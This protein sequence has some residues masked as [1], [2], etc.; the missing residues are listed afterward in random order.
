MCWTDEGQPR[1]NREVEGQVEGLRLF[2]SYQDAV[3]IDGEAIE[4]ECTM[5]TGFS[6]LSILQEIQQDLERKNIQP[7]EF[8]DRI[9]FMSIFNDIEWKT[10]DENWIS[11][12]KNYAMKFSQEHWTYLGPGSEEK[13]YKKEKGIPQP[14]TWYSDTKKLVI[15]CSKVSVLWVIESWSRKEVKKTIHSLQWRF[16]WIQNS[17]SKQLVHSVNQLSV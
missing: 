8:K 1:S 2:S 9:I 10:N 15:L 4:F 5:F 11:N 6:S 14:T 3:G 17:R 16:R 13:W 12:V 7:E